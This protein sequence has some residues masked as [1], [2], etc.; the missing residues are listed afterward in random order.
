M[1]KELDE[2]VAKRQKK[3]KVEEEKTV[4]EKTTLHVKDPTDYQVIFM[5]ILLHTHATG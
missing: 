5:N 4:E 2:L 1:Q 3:G